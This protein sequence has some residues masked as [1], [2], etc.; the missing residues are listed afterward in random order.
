[1]LFTQIHLLASPVLSTVFPGLHP[2][3]ACNILL[4][5][6]E[7]KVKIIQLSV[8]S[9]GNILVMFLFSLFCCHKNKIEGQR[10]H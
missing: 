3:T 7:C 8:Q 10:M 5:L 1:M 6:G 4:D 9:R 2:H